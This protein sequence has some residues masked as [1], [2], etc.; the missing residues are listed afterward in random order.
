MSLIPIPKLVTQLEMTIAANMS[1]MV[2]YAP[3]ALWALLDRN[4]EMEFWLVDKGVCILDHQGMYNVTQ[5]T[6]IRG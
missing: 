1:V 4:K 3:D 2:R 6:M 5:R